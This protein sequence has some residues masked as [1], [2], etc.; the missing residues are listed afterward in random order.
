MCK[1]QHIHMLIC[2]VYT[3]KAPN[4][5]AALIYAKKNIICVFPSQSFIIYSTALSLNSISFMVQY[6]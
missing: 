1:G 6:M 5:N 4:L 2:T 3:R